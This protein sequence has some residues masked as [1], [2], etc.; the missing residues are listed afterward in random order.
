MEASA[1]MAWTQE[2]QRPKEVEALGPAARQRLM[3]SDQEH[4]SVLLQAD[5]R[6]V[7]I[8]RITLRRREG[9]APSR[10]RDGTHRSNG[11]PKVSAPDPTPPTRIRDPLPRTDPR[12]EPW[13]VQPENPRVDRAA[14]QSAVAKP[15]RH[16][17]SAHR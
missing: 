10:S 17:D 4:G 16:A 1:L 12:R 15:R 3:V 8:E 13:A 7:R 6:A 14:G 9:R 2:Q 5:R 11:S